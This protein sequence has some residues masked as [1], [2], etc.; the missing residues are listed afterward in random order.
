VS[1]KASTISSSGGGSG[2]GACGADCSAITNHHLVVDYRRRNCSQPRSEVACS[3]ARNRVTSG[4][5]DLTAAA[6]VLPP[7]P[8]ND[9]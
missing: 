5:L 7:P 4:Q 6:E 1:I 2:P 3:P 9:G 8:A